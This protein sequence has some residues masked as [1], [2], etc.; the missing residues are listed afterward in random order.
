MLLDVYISIMA[1]I[2]IYP[3]TQTFTKF[4]NLQLLHNCIK[5]SILV[6]NCI[7][8]RHVFAVV[9]V[10]FTLNGLHIR[11]SAGLSADI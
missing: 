11:L 8:C 4:R 2:L 1:V 5:R 7:L 9:Q 3:V 6:I 10:H